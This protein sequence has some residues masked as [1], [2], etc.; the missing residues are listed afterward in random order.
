MP[1]CESALLLHTH[2]QAGRGACCV[3]V[4]TCLRGSDGLA[5]VVVLVVHVQLRPALEQLP[6]GVDNG[7]EREGCVDDVS[8]A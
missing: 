6:K 1:G 5:H 8:R 2:L 4:R 3:R 7:R